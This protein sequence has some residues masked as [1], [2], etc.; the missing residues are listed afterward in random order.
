MCGRSDKLASSR[1]RQGLLGKRE[2]FRK[3]NGIDGDDGDNDH[4]DAGDGGD[5]GGPVPV[6]MAMVA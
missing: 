3:R 2:S 1:Q 4:G 6:T 5:G